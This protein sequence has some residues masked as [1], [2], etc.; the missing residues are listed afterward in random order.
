MRPN[1]VRRRALARL[2]ALAS[3]PALGADFPAV[4]RGHSMVFPR[5]YGSHP[6]FR[7]EWWYV[8]GW[9][10]T[11]D[12]SPLGFQVTFFRAR[13]RD[14]EANPSR[15][16]PRQLLLAHAAVSDPRLGKLRHEQRAARAGFELAEAKQDRTDVWIHDWSLKQADERYRTQIRARDFSFKLDLR[17]T[18]RPLLQGERGVSQKGPNPSAA[19]YYYSIPQLVVEGSVQL[20][21]HEL[22]VAGRAWLDHEWSSEYLEKDAVGWD[23][24]GINFADGGALMAFRMRDAAGKSRWAAATERSADG[25]VTS[26]SP[27]QVAFTP[28]RWWRSPRS[29]ARYPVAVEVR[30]GAR[31]LTLAPLMDDQ[32]LGAQTALGATYW[33]GAVRALENGKEIGRGYLELTGYAEPLNI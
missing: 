27:E 12:R 1:L 14:A 17:Q 30:A 11:H 19:S 32:E 4:T 8:T 31:V 26:L 16:A 5:D 2:L 33:E 6:E 13:H 25:L 10:T 7:I 21:G 9:L 23:W 15:F 18:Q 3:F 20:N 22:K 29:D 28:R 24:I